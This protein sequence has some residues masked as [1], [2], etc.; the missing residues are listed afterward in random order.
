MY[1]IHC[2]Y[3]CPDRNGDCHSICERY[4]SERAKRTEEQ[5][6][7]AKYKADQWAISDALRIGKARFSKR[8]LSGDS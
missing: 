8:K 7:E 1:K 3:Q 5:R 2:C 4:K 6:K